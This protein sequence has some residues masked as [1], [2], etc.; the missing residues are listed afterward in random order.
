MNAPADHD[1]VDVPAGIL[2]RGTGE[3]ALDEIAAAQHYPRRWFEDESPSQPLP[4]AAFRIDRHPVTNAQYRRF[5]DATGYRTLSEQRGRS[6]VYGSEFWEETAGAHWRRPTG[7]DGPPALDDHPTVHLTLGDATAYATWAGLRLPTETEWEY[8]A[9]GPDSTRTWPWGNTWNPDAASTADTT[10]TPLH[11]EHA[12]RAWWNSQRV[13][14]ALP[15][16]TPIGGRP[17]GASPFY[18]HDLAGNVQEWTSTVYHPYDPT[19]DYGTVYSHIVG[20]YVVLRGGS[21]MHYRWQTRCA[22]R[23]AADPGYTN[24]ATGFRC[25]TER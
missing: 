13:A 4:V 14:H 3:A 16:T 19:R 8:A 23:I 18:V 17:H 5:A 22:E 9:R 25:A 12:W 10:S 11:D 24:F 15:A 2:L 1:L 7:P 20:R 6:L 21:W